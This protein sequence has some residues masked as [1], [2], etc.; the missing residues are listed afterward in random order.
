MLNISTVNIEERER[1][2]NAFEQKTKEKRHMLLTTE[3]YRTSALRPIHFQS[4]NHQ[5]WIDCEI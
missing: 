2:A 4:N 1:M 5:C 3:T